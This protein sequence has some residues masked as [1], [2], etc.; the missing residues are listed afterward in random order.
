[1]DTKF[2]L[3]KKAILKKTF[4]FGG[5]TFLSRILGIFREMLQIR[6]LGLKSISDAFITAYSI[7]NSLR[8]V[9]AEGALSAA[10][11]PTFVKLVK[12]DGKDRVSRLMSASFLFFEG[13]VLILCVLVFL[14]PRAVISLIAAGFSE[15]QFAY[16]IPFLR[17]LFPFIFFI[18]S[19][20]LLA[21]ALQS[22][23]HF[24]M[25][26]FAPVLM[27]FFY[28]SGL[29]LCLYFKYSLM[30]LCWGIIIG[31]AVQFLMHLAFYFYYEFSFG[32]INKEALKDFKSVLM[33]F[34]SCL[35]AVSVMEINFLI[36]RRALSF[37][38]KG[39]VSIVYYGSAFMRIP[40]GIFAVGFATVLLSHLSRVVTYAPK[41]LSFYLLEA[42]KLTCWV[43]LPASFFLIFVSEKLF[44]TLMFNGTGTLEQI[45]QASRVLMIFSLSLVFFSLAKILTNIFYALHDTSR[46]A[47]ISLCATIVNIAGNLLSLRYLGD[48]A[49]FGIAGSTA[50][51]GTIL[52]IMSY[53]YLYRK[54][55]VTF[56]LKNFAS[57]ITR[58]LFQIT[59]LMS[60]FYFIH[61]L[62]FYALQ[63]TQYY[64]FFYNRWGYWFIAGPLILFFILLIFVSKKLFRVKLYF[65]KR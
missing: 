20:A 16:A 6:L 26:A 48:N 59:V 8:K 40:L 61:S 58:Y 2:K 34:L 23:N 56:Y 5:L 64:T 52:A 14:Y 4:Q 19:S 25:P 18:S 50:V 13:I 46:P 12:T 22:V 27:N 44:S 17:V 62:I 54:H 9:F 49:I 3:S 45:F 55:K 38:G 31:G 42:T 24:F 33:K 47:I 11:V 37:L 65:L 57:F 35:F 53:A 7:P 60:L 1:M 41:R 21:G 10:S 43:I 36:D 30:L 32:E 28:I 29:G 15:E 39:S 63:Q 51:Y